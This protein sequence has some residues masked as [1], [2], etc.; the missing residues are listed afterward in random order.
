MWRDDKDEIKSC[1]A[2]TSSSHLPHHHHLI[3]ILIT[4]NSKWVDGDEDG[5]R[6]GGGGEDGGQVWLEEEGEVISVTGVGW[7][8]NMSKSFCLLSSSSQH[9][10]IIQHTGGFM[11][12]GEEGG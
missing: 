3:I 11:R 7:E 12:I 9:H 2:P 4:K 8:G 1:N 5:K 10:S 6:G